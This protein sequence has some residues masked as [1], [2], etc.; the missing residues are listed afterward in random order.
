[1]PYLPFYLFHVFMKA[2]TNASSASVAVSLY[3]FRMSG[4]YPWISAPFGARLLK[5]LT[6]PHRWFCS[7]VAL[8]VSMM[9]FD[10]C[11]FLAPLAWMAMSLVPVGGDPST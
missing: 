5:Y 8:A 2:S 10:I 3:L 4:L 6:E 11:R 1:M 9:L 7:G